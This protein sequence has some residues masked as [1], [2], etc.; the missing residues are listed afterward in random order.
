MSDLLFLSLKSGHI[1]L[2]PY[3]ANFKVMCYNIYDR[4]SFE[5]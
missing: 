3:I 4:F 1:I 5:I 2:H